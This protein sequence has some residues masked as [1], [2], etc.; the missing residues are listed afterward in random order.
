MDICLLVRPI[1]TIPI[2]KKNIY[3][4]YLKEHPLY[5]KRLL[6]LGFK[7][8]VLKLLLGK[9]DIM[10]SIFF[11]NKKQYN[12]KKKAELPLQFVGIANF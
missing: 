9:D 3:A 6:Q 1:L 5:I 12:T 8:L 10:V 2:E 11:V 4:N 7:E